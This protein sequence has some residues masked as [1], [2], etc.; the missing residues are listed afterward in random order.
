MALFT[1]THSTWGNWE[2]ILQGVFKVANSDL[3]IIS[4]SVKL[5]VAVMI[6]NC[7]LCGRI[8]KG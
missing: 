7:P 1:I 6:Y 5:I 8:Q 2:R 4:L 3:L